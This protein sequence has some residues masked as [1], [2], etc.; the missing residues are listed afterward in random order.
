MNLRLKIF[1][2]LA[3]YGL[4]GCNQNYDKSFEENNQKFEINRSRLE[5][6]ISGLERTYVKNWNR[7]KSLNIKVDSLNLSVKDEL[8]SLGIGSIELSPNINSVCDKDYMIILNVVEGWNIRTLRVVQ[9]IYAPCE[10]RAQ[11]NYHSHDGYNID[12]WDQGD[13]WFLFSDTD[14]I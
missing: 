4:T 13:N 9:L 14:F 12:T 6:I 2:L 7:R 1:T 3:I 5:L 10:K 11:K 8:V